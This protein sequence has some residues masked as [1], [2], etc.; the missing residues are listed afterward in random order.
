MRHL[1]PLEVWAQARVAYEMGDAAAQVC[2]RLGIG[3]TAFFA[4]AKAGGWRRRDQPDAVDAEV[5]PGSAEVLDDAR[6]ATELA[7][8]AMARASAA[9][10]AGRLH[11]AQ[12]WTRLAQTLRHLAVQEGEQANWRRTLDEA[13][14]EDEA[15]ELAG[16]CLADDEPDV[17]N[18]SAPEVSSP[19]PSNT[20]TITLKPNGANRSLRLRPLVSA[21]ALSLDDMEALAETMETEKANRRPSRPDPDLRPAPA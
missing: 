11:E 12:G 2:R 21:Q 6:P 15:G 3:R 19:T 7:E 5:G 1:I 14:T 16:F 18:G 17:A 20:E 9:I 8:H 13:M 10:L 4:A